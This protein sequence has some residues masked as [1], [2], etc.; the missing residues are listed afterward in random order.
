M[1]IFRWQMVRNKTEER[2]LCVCRQVMREILLIWEF[3][4]TREEIKNILNYTQ[5][6]LSLCLAFH[7]TQYKIMSLL[8]GFFF[9]FFNSG[10]VISI[11]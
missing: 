2:V 3:N 7:N 6:P 10:C 9:F 5:A 1:C 8:V 11:W 4:T